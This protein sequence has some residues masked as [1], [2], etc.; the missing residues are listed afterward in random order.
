MKFVYI[1][2]S[3]YTGGALLNQEQ[4]FQAASAIYISEVDAE[5]LIKEHFPRIQS[6]ELKYKALSF[7]NVIG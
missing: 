2:E 6:D 1:D 5:K 3:G 7:K 4:P